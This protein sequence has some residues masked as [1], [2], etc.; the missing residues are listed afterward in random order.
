LVEIYVIVSKTRRRKI[1]RRRKIRKRR[2]K[3]ERK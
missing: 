1:I 2:R 3:G